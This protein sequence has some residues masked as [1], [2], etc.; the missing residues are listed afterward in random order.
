[1]DAEEHEQLSTLPNCSSTVGVLASV[2][3]ATTLSVLLF[4]QAA[5]G[6]PIARSCEINVSILNPTAEHNSRHR[7]HSKR[8][9]CCQRLMVGAKII[10]A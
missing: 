8:P 3:N 2:S 6:A 1:M 5:I 4:S 10:V 7:S 9:Q